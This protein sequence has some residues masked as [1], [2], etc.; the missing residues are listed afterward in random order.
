MRVLVV[1]DH[2]ATARAIHVLLS[3]RGCSVTLSMTVAEALGSLE[4]PPDWVILDLM[5]PD[6]DGLTVLRAIRQSAL[7]TRVAIAT[8]CDQPERLVQAVGLRPD[9]LMKK[10]IDFGSLTEVM[11]LS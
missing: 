9:V 2:Q 7:P 1:E 11:K 10:P 5:L 8:G 4:P 6:G 3:H